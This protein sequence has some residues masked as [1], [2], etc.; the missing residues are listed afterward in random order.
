M[1]LLFEKL[2]GALSQQPL[3]PSLTIVPAQHLG[4]KKMDACGT[5]Y[6]FATN[7]GG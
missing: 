2:H 3:A 4:F 5:P 6:L 1:N 7:L